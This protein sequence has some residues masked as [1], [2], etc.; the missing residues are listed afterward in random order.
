VINAVVEIVLILV[1]IVANGIFS[2]S[3][4][5][6]VSS[7]K[8]RLEQLAEQGNGR[9]GAA[10]RLAN[11]ARQTLSNDRRRRV[12]IRRCSCGGGCSH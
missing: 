5:A 6:V 7:R 3:E 11:A 9:A 12:H 8:I 4:I 2:G 1:L 10:L